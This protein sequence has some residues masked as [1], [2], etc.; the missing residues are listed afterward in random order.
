MGHNYLSGSV[1]LGETGSIQ[2]TGSFYGA[3]AGD[4]TG[5]TTIPFSSVYSILNPGTDRVLTT[6]DSSGNSFEG[7]PG[8]TYSESSKQLTISA[9]SH[10]LILQGLQSAT[11]PNTSSYLALD[12]STNRV[13]LTSSAQGGGGSGGTIGAAEDGDYTDGL[14]TDFTT[15]TPVGTPIDRFN[16]VSILN[17]S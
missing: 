13:V 2:I 8:F 4:G 7:H 16:E 9:S 6:R 15:S 11:L 3:F 14:Y 5:I 10:P 1:T 17:L 12:P